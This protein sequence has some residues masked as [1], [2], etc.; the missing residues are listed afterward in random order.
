MNLFVAHRDYII[1]LRY[2]YDFGVYSKDL[3]RHAQAFYSMW[4]TLGEG[5]S[6]E[7]NDFI[8]TPGQYTSFCCSSEPLSRDTANWFEVPEY[9]LITVMKEESQLSLNL[10]DFD[11]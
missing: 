7:E 6:Y 9:T 4:F 11:L 8:M 10:V 3:T 1:V 5:F 2:T